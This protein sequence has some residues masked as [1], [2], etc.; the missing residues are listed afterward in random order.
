MKSLNRRLLAY[1]ALSAVAAS[2][3]SAQ[4]RAA[5]LAVRARRSSRRL[6]PLPRGMGPGQGR[7]QL[8][9]RP[10]QARRPP[11]S[12][13]RQ[14]RRVAPGT[15]A[16]SSS[17]EMP[18][19][20]QQPRPAKDEVAL[21]SRSG[22]RPAPPALRRRRPAATFLARGRRRGSSSPTSRR[23]TPARGGSPRYF[24]LAHLYNAGRAE[25]ERRPPATPSNCSTACRGTRTSSR[26]GPSTRRR[27]SAIDLR[28]YSWTAR[29]WERRLARLPLPRRPDAERQAVAGLPSRC[30]AS[31]PARRLVRGHRL[32]AAAVPRLLNCRHGRAGSGCCRWTCRGDIQQEKVARAGFNGSGVSKN[33]R[34][35]ERHD[36]G[37]IGGSTGRATTS[38]NNTGRQNLFAHPLGPARATSSFQPRRRRDHLQPAQRPAGLHARRRARPAHR[39]GADRDRQRPQT[40]RPSVETAS[41]ACRATPAA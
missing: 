17:G 2:T 39:Q 6:F 36:A 34:L 40:A 31:R 9:P 41:R 20:G 11:A 21:I 12:H 22:S 32:A 29:T 26:R 27:S 23:S 30:R 19:A 13:P 37:R 18:P 4:P 10:R 8:H 7:L 15:G 35:I 16:V 3:A 38:P 28:D 14:A 25:D 33:N 1:L 24:S 5:D